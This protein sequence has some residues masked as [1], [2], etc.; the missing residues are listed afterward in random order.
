MAGVAV[1]MKTA[2][3]GLQ[4]VRAAETLLRYSRSLPTPTICRQLNAFDGELAAEAVEKS[5]EELERRAD[6]GDDEALL[7]ALTR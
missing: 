6:A 5:V 3:H 1:F 2:Y 4:R 7:W